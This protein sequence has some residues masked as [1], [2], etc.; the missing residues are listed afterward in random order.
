MS[1][2]DA[3][4]KGKGKAGAGKG[5]GGKG[6][7]K[8]GSKR[9]KKVFRDTIKGITKPAIRRLARRAGVKRISGQVYEDSRTLLKV[10]V[11]SVVYYSLMYKDC[12]ER[13]TI[14]LKDVVM[15]LKRRGNML[16]GA[17]IHQEKKRS[18]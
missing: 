7:A 13:K 11:D 2:R 5:G 1:T 16:I 8:G 17:E 9:H 15:A 14:S 3:A 10:F 4:A 12:V 6:T 18:K